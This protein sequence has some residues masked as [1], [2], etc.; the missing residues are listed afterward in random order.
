MGPDALEVKIIPFRVTVKKYRRLRPIPDGPSSPPVESCERGTGAVRLLC[1]ADRVLHKGIVRTFLLCRV[2]GIGCRPGGKE[3]PASHRQSQQCRRHDEKTATFPAVKALDSPRCRREA[4]P[5]PKW[6][7]SRCRV[8]M[9]GGGIPAG[10]GN[11]GSGY[12]QRPGPA[13]P[14]RRPVRNPF[15]HP[16]DEEGTG[17]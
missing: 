10:D 13:P 3:Y 11:T 7:E 9:P 6:V 12:P 14:R 5:P 4:L 16:L 1:L 15:H 17:G 2:R 8:L